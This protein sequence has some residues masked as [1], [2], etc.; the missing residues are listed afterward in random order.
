MIGDGKLFMRC[1]QFQDSESEVL[2]LQIDLLGDT[3]NPEVVCVLQGEIYAFSIS[4][5]CD[6]RE[7]FWRR[8]MVNFRV[9]GVLRIVLAYL[10]KL[11]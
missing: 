7:L 4:T 11:M 10:R 5:V 9:L 8:H 6:K 1:R 2:M 3:A